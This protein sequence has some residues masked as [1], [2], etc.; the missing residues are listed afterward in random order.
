MFHFL[1]SSLKLW[2][3]MYGPYILT[4]LPAINSSVFCQAA[5]LRSCS[6]IRNRFRSDL[7][8]ASSASCGLSLQTADLW[9]ETIRKKT[10]FWYLLVSQTE[11][12]HIIHTTYVYIYIYIISVFIYIYRHIC[13][14][15]CDIVR[16]HRLTPWKRLSSKHTKLAGKS[17]GQ[18]DRG[19]EVGQGLQQ[20]TIHEVL[21]M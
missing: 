20:T 18:Q 16:E 21:D 8:N 4:F 19:Q 10:S 15:L 2:N 9:T 11:A 7:S 6:R 12:L 13:I 14:L 5:T 1:I 3:T 17:Q